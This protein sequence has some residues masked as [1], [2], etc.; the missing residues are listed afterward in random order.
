MTTPFTTGRG[1]PFGI[2]GLVSGV[3]PQKSAVERT[4]GR[5]RTLFRGRKLTMV[6]KKSLTNWEMIQ[7]DEH[8][9]KWVVP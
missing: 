1:P 4:F 5:G 3:Q 8:L 9:F 6:I 7:L 2:P